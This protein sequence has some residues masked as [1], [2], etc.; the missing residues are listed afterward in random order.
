MRTALRFDHSEAQEG[1]GSSQTRQFEF[2]LKP[3]AGLV[4]RPS[5]YL[6]AA[7][8]FWP[9]RFASDFGDE[10]QDFARVRNAI[11]HDPWLLAEGLRTPERQS[12]MLLA[13]TRNREQEFAL[14]T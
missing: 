8:R 5:R 9:P 6:G 7:D 3:G 4:V 12:D 13:Y 14:R 11:F 2:D 10:A 1:L